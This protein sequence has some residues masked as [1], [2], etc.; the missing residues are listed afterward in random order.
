MRHLLLT[1]ELFTQNGGIPRIL[2]LYARV[3]SD[4]TDRGDTFAFLSFGEHAVDT[5]D[6]RKYT[7][8][9]LTAWAVSD[10]SRLR[11]TRRALRWARRHDHVICGHI[12]LLPVAALMRCMNPRLTIDLVAHGIEVWGKL[13]VAQRVALRL[14]RRVLCVS[15]YTR[16][17]MVERNPALAAKCV[18]VP[19]GLDINFPIADCPCEPATPPEL[20]CVSRLC[21]SDS[22]KGVDKLIE[23]M[24]A[25]LRKVPGVRLR[26]IGE[27]D[28]LGR[29]RRLADK[30]GVA[31]AVR[32]CGHVSDAE[33]ASAFTACTAFVLPSTGEGFGLVYLE[34]MA[35][36]R[37]CLGVSAGGVPE[38]ISAE[39]GILVPPDDAGKLEEGLIALLGRK[40]DRSAIIAWV[41][42]FSHDQ[43]RTRLLETQPSANRTEP[44]R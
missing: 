34:A 30:R 10:Y 20:L 43:F 36:G 40:W 44:D 17:R 42:G 14:T 19:N 6:L 25:L 39:T 3:L 13:S 9:G 18:V 7:G 35:H 31:A 23:A 2:R 21:K 28:D 4:Q 26:I 32:F 11:F 15:E 37:P 33:L 27:G 41:R 5:R 22:Y 1:P 29:L 16:Q 24:P 38:V 8:S 12:H